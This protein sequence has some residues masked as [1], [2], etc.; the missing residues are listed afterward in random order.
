MCQQRSPVTADAD[1]QIDTLSEVLQQRCGSFCQTGD[2]VKY[3]AEEA[4]RRAEG[5]RL[6]SESQQYLEESLVLYRRAAAT[7]SDE[8]VKDVCARYRRLGFVAG[9]LS[10]TARSCQ[11][12]F[13]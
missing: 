11:P 2:V 5:T 7:L 9:E 6:P 4:L 13:S 1:E 12:I 10:S 8:T 3:K